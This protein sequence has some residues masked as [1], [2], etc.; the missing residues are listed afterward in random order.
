MLELDKNF[1]FFY[2]GK[3]LKQAVSQL[4]KIIFDGY[5]SFTTFFAVFSLKSLCTFTIVAAASAR[6]AFTSVFTRV[7]V[8]QICYENKKT[9][10]LLLDAR[11]R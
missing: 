7:L 1:F 10:A 5:S 11:L 3:I 2:S 4:W 8:T 6:L 9:N